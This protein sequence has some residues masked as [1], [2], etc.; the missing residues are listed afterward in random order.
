[1]TTNAARLQQQEL[2]TVTAIPLNVTA[3]NSQATAYRC[4]GLSHDIVSF[5]TRAATFRF[6]VFFVRTSKEDKQHTKRLLSKD[7]AK[8]KKLAAL[9]IEYDFP[10]FMATLKDREAAEGP[11]Q[12]KPQSANKAG[13][14]VRCCHTPVHTVWLRF[15]TCI[16]GATA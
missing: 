16:D 7:Y 8:R 13:A 11:L 12:S 4:P 15:F 10:G 9:G 1:M 2:F 5:L 3:L 14:T 6:F